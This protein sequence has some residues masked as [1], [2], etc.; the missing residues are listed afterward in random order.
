MSKA[1]ARAEHVGAEQ[2]AGAGALDRR[3]KS[4]EGVRIF[5]AD[6]DIALRRADR[7]AGDR[8]AFDQ[9]ERVALHQH[10][11]GE[12]AAVALVGVADDIF[13]VGLRRRRR[14]AI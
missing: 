3:A 2:P 9:Q 7:D 13:L 4:V 10:A 14:C 1:C 5:G 6:V 12:G 8:H 11:V